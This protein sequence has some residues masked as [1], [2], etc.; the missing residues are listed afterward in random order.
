MVDIPQLR[1]FV[2]VSFQRN[3][4]RASTSLRLTPSPVG[5]T[6]R[7]LEREFGHQLFER[8]YHDL[9]PTEAAGWLLP[10]AVEILAQVDSVIA[11][12]D[13]S[14][15]PLRLGVTPLAP[16]RY[17]DRLAQALVE[18]DESAEPLADDMSFALLHMLS[19]G[20][21]DGVIV[22]LPVD[23]PGITA[24]PLGRYQFY[25]FMPE[26]AEYSAPRINITELRDT[27][28]A[29]LPIAFQPMPMTALLNQLVEVGIGEVLE[30]QLPDL[31]NLTSRLR[32]AGAVM[33]NANAPDVPISSMMARPGLKA[34]P[35]DGINFEFQIGV[36][37][38]SAD[39]TCSRRV[40]AL[41]ER[42]APD[43]DGIEII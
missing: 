16:T 20:R 39:S 25:A 32:Q 34:L 31:M 37:W 30:L 33:L 5:R 6:I 15:R 4:K 22:H 36:A 11:G 24:R 10:R 7:E 27:P 8:E 38:R 23:L 9:V 41:A 21:L 28:V 29:M 1:A 18:S 12:P 3:I 42:L 13:S 40:A 14:R 17:T 35:L 19:H 43:G 2:E 26:E